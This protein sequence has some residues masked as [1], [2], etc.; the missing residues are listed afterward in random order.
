MKNKIM[1]SVICNTF[2][3]KSYIKDA[4]NSFVKQE[5]NFNFEILV[6]DDASTDGTQDIIKSYE[7]KYPDLIK[8]IYQEENQYS[9]GK[10]ITLNFQ[11]PRARGK[12]IALC[13]GDDYWTDSKKL[14]KQ[15]DVLEK[16]SNINICVHAV[17]I[18]QEE[19]IIGRLAPSK[20]DKIFSPEAVLLYGGYFIGTCSI[21]YRHLIDYQMPR[22]R[23]QYHCDYTIQFHGSLN[24]GMFY[25]HEKMGVYRFQSKGSWNKTVLNNKE[26]SI[27]HYLDM[28]NML[29]LLNVETNFKYEKICQ[30]LI[31]EYKYRIATKKEDKKEIIEISK[32]ISLIG[33][34]DILRI[35]DKKTRIKQYL[36]YRLPMLVIGIKRI[37]ENKN[38]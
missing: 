16:Y 21:M 28:I 22:Y 20:K 26:K 5:T 14:Q 27:S 1:V 23:R 25:L 24:D 33:N 12:Y 4:L 17:D 3:Q 35:F 9:K 19:K 38:G 13:E 7:K 32:A 34:K 36:K 2:N 18:L 29:E 31:Y 8:V 15:V 11:L 30:Y 10:N 37:K 6:H